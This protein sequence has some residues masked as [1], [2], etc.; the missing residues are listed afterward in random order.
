MWICCYATASALKAGSYLL[1]NS[2][3]FSFENRKN[4]SKILNASSNFSSCRTE[5]LLCASGKTRFLR[6]HY[7]F[8]SFSL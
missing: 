8:N 3:R 2:L 6:L 4:S 5:N 7:G 1:G